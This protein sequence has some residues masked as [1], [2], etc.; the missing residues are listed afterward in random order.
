MYGGRPGPDVDDASA[1]PFA[2]PD[3]TSFSSCC[4]ALPPPNHA[5]R[6]V[7][8]F[9]PVPGDTPPGAGRRGDGTCAT[10]AAP[11]VDAGP[12]VSA[13]AMQQSAPD[14]DRLRGRRG[15]GLSEETILC[16]C[17]C[18]MVPFAGLCVSQ[19]YRGTMRVS[20]E[21]RLAMAPSGNEPAANPE[22]EQSQTQP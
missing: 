20:L 3:W 11:E 16:T 4:L 2:V 13:A 22:N 6:P 15:S 10:N 18:R 8:V 7:L 12:D 17:A 14:T 1:S 21:V 5:P 9:V 19:H